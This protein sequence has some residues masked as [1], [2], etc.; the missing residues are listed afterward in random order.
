MHMYANTAGT[1]TRARASST[2][3]FSDDLRPPFYRRLLYSY[4]P[5]VNLR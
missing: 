3:Q 4:W 2:G 5:I 1:C